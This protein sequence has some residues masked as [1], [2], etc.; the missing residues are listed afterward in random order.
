V[1]WIGISLTNTEKNLK[2]DSA[3]ELQ[4][5]WNTR[6][7]IVSGNILH[8]LLHR[9]LFVTKFWKITHTVV[10]ETIRIFELSMALLIA[11]TTFKNISKLY[12]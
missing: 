3:I 11:E 2:N 4:S 8:H 5:L 12:L 9:S 6:F 7:E 10:P 1:L